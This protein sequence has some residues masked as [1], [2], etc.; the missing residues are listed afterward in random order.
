M[1]YIIS[2]IVAVV[3]GVLAGISI[4]SIAFG[5]VISALLSLIGNLIC[6][7]LIK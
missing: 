3:G 6:A 7:K 1:K 4:H 2:S 5:A